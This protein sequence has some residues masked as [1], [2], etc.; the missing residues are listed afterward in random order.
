MAFLKIKPNRVYFG[1]NIKYF[2]KWMFGHCSLALF[3]VNFSDVKFERS[4]P[5]DEGHL[6]MLLKI[7]S[8]VFPMAPVHQDV[9]TLHCHTFLPLWWSVLIS[10]LNDSTFATDLSVHWEHCTAGWAWVCCVLLGSG[11]CV[12]PSSKVSMNSDS[13]GDA[14][15]MWVLAWHFNKLQHSVKWVAGYIPNEYPCLI[16]EMDLCPLGQE[17]DWR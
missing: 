4:A 10:A 1:F 15:Y 13:S 9:K 7:E 5:M 3:N 6:C 8:L 2:T 17:E 11:V 14:R 12:K 16:E